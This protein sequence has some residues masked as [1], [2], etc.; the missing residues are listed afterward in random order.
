MLYDSI[1]SGYNSTRRA[2][3]F[4]TDKLFQFLIP[5]TNGTYLDIGCGTGNYL[6]TLCKKGLSFYG[7][8]PS[9][10]MLKEARAKNTGAVLVKAQAEKLPIS[11]N[12]FDGSVAMLTL[13]HWENL[14]FGIRE[15]HR[16]LKPSSRFVVFSF[17]PE[18][19]KGYWL[20]H[21]FPL[22]MEKCIKLTKSLE[23]TKEFFFESGFTQIETENY[24]I[25]ADLQD[26][27]LYS[28][29]FKPEMY[30]VDDIRKNSSAFSV[31]SSSVEVEKGTLHLSQDISSGEIKNVMK[32]Y[33]NNLGDYT[34]LIA[35]K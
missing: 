23:E 28:N 34:F 14:L 1:G 10:V 16:V 11:N 3:P 26:H 2:D 9:E 24:F 20:C 15:I 29:K 25:K 6:E 8:D 21:Y 17:T 18:Q 32:N 33:E 4:I 30:L 19:M 5:T 35:T 22:M 13:H 27:F 7:I 12:F 31:Y